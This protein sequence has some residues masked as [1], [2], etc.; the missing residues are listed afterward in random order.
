DLLIHQSERIDQEVLLLARHARRDVIEVQVGHAVEVD[1]PVAR[2]EIDAG[3]PFGGIH[4]GWR[5]RRS[6]LGLSGVDL[7]D[8]VHRR[9]PQQSSQLGWILASVMIWRQT[10]TSVS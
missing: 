5:L 10:A 2:G 7:R 1:Q 6:G 8:G 3:L 4:A 9:S